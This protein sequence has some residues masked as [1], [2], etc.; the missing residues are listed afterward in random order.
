MLYNYIET[1]D[2]KIFCFFFFQKLQGIYCS[3][4]Q[5]ELCSLQSVVIQ[6]VSQSSVILAY[7]EG[8]FSIREDSTKNTYNK[9]NDIKDC[10]SRQNIQ[11]KYSRKETKKQRCA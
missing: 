8:H 6:Q 9:E 3:A 10:D 7:E 4:S 11:W 1:Y 2:R 5:K